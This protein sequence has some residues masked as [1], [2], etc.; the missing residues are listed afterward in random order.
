MRIDEPQPERR[1]A[2]NVRTSMEKPSVSA[3]PAAPTELIAPGDLMPGQTAQRLV[4]WATT[5][6][7]LSADRLI[8]LGLLAGVFIAIGGAFFTGVMAESSLGHGP[9]RLLG[10]IAFS[11][12]L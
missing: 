1:Q 12:G 8:V 6:S 11:G 9:S 10:G 4:D 3:R 2:L 7:T 5:K